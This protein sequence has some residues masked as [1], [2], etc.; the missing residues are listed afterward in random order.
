M[1]FCSWKKIN[2]RRWNEQDSC[3]NSARAQGTLFVVVNHRFH[4]IYIYI[5]KKYLSYWAFTWYQNV[6]FVKNIIFTKNQFLSFSRDA[7]VNCV[8]C[9]H[10]F[11]SLWFIFIMCTRSFNKSVRG[12]S[13]LSNRVTSCPGSYAGQRTK[14]L[15]LKDKRVKWKKFTCWEV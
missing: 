11:I 6:I 15:S 13:D 12:N 9:S 14:V 5:L 3:V 8:W 1:F 4:Y 10:L 7:H 2:I